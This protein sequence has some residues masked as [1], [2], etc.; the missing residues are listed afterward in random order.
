MLKTLFYLFVSLL[1]IFFISIIVP[2]FY[3]LKNV[4]LAI[5]ILFFSVLVSIT[6]E[7]YQLILFIIVFLPIVYVVDVIGLVIL[8][9]IGATIVCTSKILDAT[10]GP[11]INLLTNI[12][13]WIYSKCKWR[14]TQE[15]TEPT[16]ETDVPNVLKFDIE[17]VKIDLQRLI[18]K[19]RGKAIIFNHNK[20]PKNKNLNERK[21]TL[22]DKTSLTNVLEGLRYGV[23]SFDDLK[24]AEIQS[25]IKEV[26]KLDHTLYDSLIVVILSHG[27][28]KWVHAYDSEYH[29]NMIFS[30]ITPTTCSSLVGKPKIFFVQACQ[31]NRRDSG[32]YLLPMNNPVVISA[33][34]KIEN[35]PS[36]PDFF[37]ARSS[38]NGMVSYRDP[39]SG[40]L[41]IQQVVEVLKKGM[42]LNSAMTLVMDHIA[43]NISDEYGNKQMPT[44]YTTLTKNFN[45]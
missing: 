19:E 32:V 44:L 8:Y 41:F 2:T 21:G 18:Y 22:M 40:S 42:N 31:G 38:Y 37:V 34:Q 9:F 43:R 11:L 20:F 28:S 39:E 33:R 1:E 16:Q 29:L 27:S 10:F 23:H 24:K 7:K 14:K 4:S 17:K 6:V 45:F 26:C 5:S 35:V 13:T 30:C 15:P 25:V 3:I 12:C 36:L